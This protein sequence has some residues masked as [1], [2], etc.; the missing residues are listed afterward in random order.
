MPEK[1]RDFEKEWTSFIDGLVDSELELSDQ[2]ILQSIQEEGEDP[3]AVADNVRQL[4]KTTNKNFRQEPLRTAKKEHAEQVAKIKNQKYNLPKR[5]S[6]RRELFFDILKNL[7][8]SFPDLT[9]QNRNFKD[10]TDQDIESGLKQL[11][12]LGYFDSESTNDQ[13]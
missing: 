7:P 8:S 2:D 9:F 6:E 1:P 12:D 13:N 5:E 11:V 4:F 10:F 3:N